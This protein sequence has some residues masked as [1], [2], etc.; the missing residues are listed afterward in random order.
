MFWT[1]YPILELGDIGGEKAPIRECKPL[2]YDGNK[3][4]RVEVGKIKTEF[5][6][7]Y[8]YTEKGRSGSV[9]VINH[10]TLLEL[11]HQYPS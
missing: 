5:K 6:S 4:C 8:I 7:G 9:P 10:E 11:P 1:D 2:S 3:Y